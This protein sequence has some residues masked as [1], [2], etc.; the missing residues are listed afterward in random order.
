MSADIMHRNPVPEL[1][2]PAIRKNLREFFGVSQLELAHHIGVS[3]QM[4][5]SYES[6]GGNNPKGEV[7]EKYAEVLKAW[8]EQYEKQTANETETE[9]ELEQCQVIASRLR[10]ISATIRNCGLRLV[11]SQ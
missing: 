4:I 10:V 9:T 6:A 3:R 2:E 8:A 5:S 1:P 7:R 11:A